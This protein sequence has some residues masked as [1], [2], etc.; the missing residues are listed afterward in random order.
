MNPEEDDAA[1]KDMIAYW[2]EAY[3]KGIEIMNNLQEACG[4]IYHVSSR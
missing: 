3:I 4:S 2:A 1:F